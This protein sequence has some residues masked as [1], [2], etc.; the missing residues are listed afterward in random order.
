MFVI[1]AAVDSLSPMKAVYCGV[2]EGWKRK[3][4]VCI[5][6]VPSRLT[7]SVRFV[8]FSA[9][10][11]TKTLT[12]LLELDFIVNSLISVSAERAE[13][14]LRRRKEEEEPMIT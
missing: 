6:T 9:G 4:M 12:G 13:F 14:G 5:P 8:V 1:V 2:K 10:L 3:R 7:R 11:F